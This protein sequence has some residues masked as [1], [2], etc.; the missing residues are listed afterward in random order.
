MTLSRS[1]STLPL[2]HKPKEEKYFVF[3]KRHDMFTHS[4]VVKYTVWFNRLSKNQHR[5]VHLNELAQEFVKHKLI[6]SKMELINAFA[7]FLKL[8]IGSNDT[9]HTV[10]IDD[11]FDVLSRSGRFIDIEKLDKI[12]DNENKLSEKTLL[13]RERR[14]LLFE[15][16]VEESLE[17]CADM[18]TLFNHY[19]SKCHTKNIHHIRALEEKNVVKS[20]L[21]THKKQVDDANQFIGKVEFEYYCN[22]Y[23]LLERIKAAKSSKQ[24]I[25]ESL[26]VQPAETRDV[27][28][29]LEELLEPHLLEMANDTRRILYEDMV[30]DSNFNKMLSPVKVS[31]VRSQRSSSAKV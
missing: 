28:R 21:D 27:M 29:P 22:Q 1:N 13:V 10:T 19:T 9:V 3:K 31:S 12:V 15:Y 4:Q 7:T 5:T 6:R 14:K 23:N 25:E 11:F 17:R 30:H 16:I 26:E 8:D 18:D 24:L 2:L 20:L